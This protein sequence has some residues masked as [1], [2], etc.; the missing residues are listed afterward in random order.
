MIWSALL[1]AL[2]LLLLVSG[3]CI[4]VRLAQSNQRIKRP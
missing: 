4:V 3:F 1:D 2:Y